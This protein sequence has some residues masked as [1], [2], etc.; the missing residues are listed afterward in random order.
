MSDG[1][2]HL[3]VVAPQCSSMQKLTR[4]GEAASALYDALVHPDLGGCVPGLPDRGSLVVGD[5]LSSTEI[6]KLIVEAIEYA[7][8]RR[9]TLLLA[10]LGHGFVPGSTNTLYLM[11]DD[12]SEDATERGVNVGELLA[13]AA[14]KPGIPSVIGIVDTCH[15]AGA[16]PRGRISSAVPGTDAPGSPWSWLRRSASRR[17]TSPSPGS[18]PA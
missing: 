2:R 4:L 7:E 3:L 15:A 8:D 1:L 6:R 11:G 18:S 13:A 9:A 17:S 10:L 12:S 5:G 16:T 14:N